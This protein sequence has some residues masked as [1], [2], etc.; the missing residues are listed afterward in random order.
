MAVEGGALIVSGYSSDREGL[1][2]VISELEGK[3]DRWRLRR[4]AAANGERHHSDRGSAG[5]PEELNLTE[6]QRE[7]IQL[8]VEEG[9]YDRPRDVSLGDLADRLDITRSA[10][11]QRLNA[12]ESKLVTDLTRH[13]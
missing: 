11:S 5:H 1:G 7:A 6:K 12:V 9:Y 13:L 3:A 4:L 10:L 8:A 2:E